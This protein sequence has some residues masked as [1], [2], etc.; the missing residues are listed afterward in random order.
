MSVPS[1][2][3]VATQ[4]TLHAFALSPDLVQKMNNDIALS[5]DARTAIVP[6]THQDRTRIEDGYIYIGAGTRASPQI[7]DTQIKFRV[8]EPTTVSVIARQANQWLVPY[9]TQA[10]V[11]IA[12]VVAGEQS[13]KEMF[14]TAEDA[15][16][17]RAWA[18]HLAGMGVMFLGLVWLMNPVHSIA[19]R[20]PA[21]GIIVR[22]VSLRFAFGFTIGASALMMALA[23]LLSQPLISIAI[24]GGGALGCALVMGGAT[25]WVRATLRRDRV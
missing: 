24:L 12:L 6:A 16:N 17:T 8:V 13:A 15:N 5:V 14:N 2:N 21:L 25:G 11:P 10:G 19:N 3:Y 20:T 9:P 18:D 4:A 7:G 22:F 1:A 23:W